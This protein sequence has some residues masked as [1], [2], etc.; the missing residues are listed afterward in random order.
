MFIDKPFQ[1][2]AL[3]GC[4]SHRLPIHRRLLRWAAT[5]GLRRIPGCL[6]WWGLGLGGGRGAGSDAVAARSP[7]ICALRRRPLGR[8]FPHGYRERPGR[9]RQRAEIFRRGHRHLRL[10]NAVT[11]TPTDGQRF[12]LVYH[13]RDITSTLPAEGSGV[14]NA[15]AQPSATKASSAADRKRI[16]AA[17]IF[18]SFPCIARNRLLR[19]HQRPRRIRPEHAGDVS[20]GVHE[21]RV[22]RAGR[23]KWTSPT[24]CWK[25]IIELGR[26]PHPIDYLSI[27]THGGVSCRRLQDCLPL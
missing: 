15:A 17:E 25:Q 12:F 19:E 26:T 6:R 2:H 21:G 13:D 22:Q 20:A 8:R 4:A 9:R 24:F 14:G 1:T 5:L 18:P 7:S 3:P 27:A 10:Q 11:A 23:L 16:Q